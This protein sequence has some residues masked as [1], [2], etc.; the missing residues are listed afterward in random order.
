MFTE[1]ERSLRV[2]WVPQSKGHRSNRF[3]IPTPVAGHSHRLY[4]VEDT[5]YRPLQRPFGRISNQL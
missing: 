5:A 2:R 1:Q 3:G 4:P